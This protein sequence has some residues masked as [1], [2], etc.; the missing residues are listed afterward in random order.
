[1]TYRNADRLLEMGNNQGMLKDHC[2]VSLHNNFVPVTKYGSKA[3]RAP[4]VT[5]V[6]G[7]IFLPSGTS[8]AFSVMLS[9]TGKYYCYTCPTGA[10][11]WRECPEMAGK[12]DGF[13][14]KTAKYPQGVA[15][16]DN[17]FTQISSAGVCIVD[18]SGKVKGRCAAPPTPSLD[19]SHC[20][21]PLT[22][23]ETCFHQDQSCQ[24]TL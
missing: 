23:S 4:A 19:A 6:T 22:R 15:I 17:E 3:D 2:G 11:S 1:M 9:D 16:V 8:K 20:S 13:F 7:A 21:E 12:Y 10:N 24:S 5:A 14:V 18:A